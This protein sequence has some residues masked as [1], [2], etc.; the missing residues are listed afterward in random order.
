MRIADRLVALFADACAD[1][2]LSSFEPAVVGLE[3]VPVAAAEMRKQK[4]AD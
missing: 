1:F 2:P 3:L 4:V